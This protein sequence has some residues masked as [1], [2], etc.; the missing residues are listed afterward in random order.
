[1]QTQDKSAMS[2]SD[3]SIFA[4]KMQ[5]QEKYVC[6]LHEAVERQV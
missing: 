4:Q 5:A 6:D 3:S 1:M 2:S